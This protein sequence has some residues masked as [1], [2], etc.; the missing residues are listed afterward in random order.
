MRNTAYF[1]LC[2][3]PTFRGKGAQH[4]QS[5]LPIIFTNHH[6]H[7]SPNITN[8]RRHHESLPPI[9]ITNHHHHH[10]CSPSDPVSATCL[11]LA[12]RSTS[13]SDSA[14]REIYRAKHSGNDEGDE[15]SI[16]PTT[17][18]SNI[19]PACIGRWARRCC[20]GLFSRPNNTVLVGKILHCRGSVFYSKILTVSD[21]QVKAC[22]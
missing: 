21:R 2:P 8:N 17:N 15:S 20:A 10:R 7:T 11:C 4:H 12:I 14:M 3:S 19:P 16:G 22:G 1:L 18:G 13:T 6:H 5:S 9:I